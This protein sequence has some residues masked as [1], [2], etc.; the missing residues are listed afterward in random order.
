MI[1]REERG[2][3]TVLRIDHGKV[4]AIDI[5]LLGML[6]VR[7]AEIEGSKTK[8]LVL[9]QTGSSIS[10]G[11]D[12]WMILDG[13]EN[14]VKGLLAS[15]RRA[16]RQAQLSRVT[17]VCGRSEGRRAPLAASSFG[18]FSIAFKLAIA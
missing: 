11:L 4:G 2:S 12:L 1:H 15:F 16:Y 9:T 13:G 14:Y 6:A 8:A 7:L 17:F 5:D 18:L 3:I 10:A